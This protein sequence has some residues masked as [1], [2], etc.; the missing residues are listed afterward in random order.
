MCDT[1]WAA[2]FW[3][4]GGVLVNTESV[5]AAHRQFIT[6]LLNEYALEIS[7]DEALDVWQTTLG[8]YFHER[9]GTEF[10]PARLGY[11]RAV[12]AVTPEG[13]AI[14]VDKEADQ[15][16]Y[17]LFEHALRTQI[18]PNNNA[19]AALATLGERD[20]HLGVISDVDTAE[21]QQILEQLDVKQFFDS[22]TTSEEVGRTKPHHS[23][24]ETALEKAEAEPTCSLMI[25]DRYRH[26]I[27]G[28]ANVGLR[29][30]AYSVDGGPAVDYRVDDLAGV[31]EIVDD[32]VPC[33][34]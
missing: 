7:V 22:I 13:M 8:D 3:D 31:I 29:T 16:W 18:Q 1:D 24:F 14:T 34:K 28:A 5:Q 33:Q 25:G 27:A 6:E 26:D 32:G 23:M 20:L 15:E 17:A 4:I 9:N 12:D 2:V 10:R 21:G 30:I 19:K 11:A